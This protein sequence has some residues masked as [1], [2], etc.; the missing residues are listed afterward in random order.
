MSEAT[1]V[2]ANGAEPDAAPAEPISGAVA[3]EGSR[4]E[5]STIAF[6][7]D[8]LDAAVVVV[9]EV[10]NTHGGQA[11]MGQLA[12]GLGQTTK[13]GAFRIKVSAAR[14]FGV[15]TVS[16]GTLTLTE[17]GQRILDDATASQ[18]SAEA[19]LEVP[20]YAA[21][22]ERFKDGTL[23]DDGGLE[24]AIRDLGV[25]PKQVQTARQ[26]FQRSAQQA[27][28]FRFGNRKLVLPAMVAATTLSPQGHAPVDQD[29]R[30]D[31]GDDLSDVV[32]HPFILGLL[33]ELPEPGK[34]EFPAEDRE[35][36]LH[37][38]KISFDLI[39]GRVKTDARTDDSLN[40][41][42]P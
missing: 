41:R 5:R 12:A 37:A 20:L 42:N 30:S 33:R 13:S 35:T 15:V 22:Y 38:A 40:P 24:A 7:Y 1:D 8:D 31:G 34:G 19:F 29:Q 10:H 21:L 11:T 14:L 26:V 4:R 36:W 39:Y 2:G 16:Q 9:R 23:P 32:K 3:G 27:G 28:F 25:T 18:A 17:R 6:P